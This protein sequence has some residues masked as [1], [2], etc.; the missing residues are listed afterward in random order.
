MLR[1]T[2]SPPDGF[3][4]FM[5]FEHG[6]PRELV[7]A[8]VSVT[9]RWNIVASFF[10]Y[11]PAR[12]LV[13]LQRRMAL[14]GY[15][16]PS[17]LPKDPVPYATRK[18][19]QVVD[20]YEAFA[21]AM[22]DTAPPNP[23]PDLQ[24]SVNGGKYTVIFNSSPYRFEALRHG[25]PWNRDLVGD[26]LVYWL[27]VELDEARK[28]MKGEPASGL[29]AARAK[30]QE[31]VRTEGEDAGVI[32]LSNEAVMDPVPDSD[33]KVYRNRYFSPLGDALMELHELLEGEPAVLTF[34]DAE[35]VE[36]VEALRGNAARLL[37][38]M[39]SGKLGAGM[40][41]V[42]FRKFGAL[43][44][45]LAKLDPEGQDLQVAIAPMSEDDEDD[46]PLWC[47]DA[48]IRGLMEGIGA[49]EDLEAVKAFLRSTGLR[50][51]TAERMRDALC[52][53]SLVGGLKDALTNRLIICRDPSDGLMRTVENPFYDPER[54]R[55]EGPPVV[56]TV[57]AMA[58]AF[59]AGKRVGYHKQGIT[60]HLEHWEPEELQSGLPGEWFLRRPK[61]PRLFVSL[62]SAEDCLSRARM[63]KNGREFFIE[64]AT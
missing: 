37:A 6:Q 9:G 21:G 1:A 54:K 52:A 8:G 15:T 14:V 26:N 28:Q 46:H 36:V 43:N 31:I 3:T 45:A 35:K 22:S 20:V 18:P 61:G 29:A 32:Y 63:A 49:T 59:K 51:S 34:T 64:D 19:G 10:N 38:G 50:E 40:Q 27:A 5:R 33:A 39:R 11:D 4:I 57:E 42:V 7:S 41:N 24:V 60:Y 58:E 13:E 30:L 47:V 12:V 44:G 48:Q 56:L 25:E 23:Q 2:L 55:E 62:Q 53:A 17:P 16:P